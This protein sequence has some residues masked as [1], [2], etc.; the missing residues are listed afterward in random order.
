MVRRFLKL[1]LWLPLLWG[2]PFTDM[3]AMVYGRKRGRPVK[4]G[5]YGNSGL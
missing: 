1:V 3:V 4:K 5:K 2:R